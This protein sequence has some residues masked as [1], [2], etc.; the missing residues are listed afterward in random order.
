MVTTRYSGNYVAG[1]YSAKAPLIK[2]A[3]FKP[4]PVSARDPR[5]SKSYQHLI[6]ALRF[7]VAKRLRPSRKRNPM[8]KGEIS[9]SSEQSSILKSLYGLGNQYQPCGQHL[10]ELGV[11][12]SWKPNI[13]NTCY[14]NRATFFVKIKPSS[15]LMFRDANSQLQTV[16]SDEKLLFRF[17]TF[18]S[19]N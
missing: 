11:I 5:R 3:K 4:T 12:A 17:R 15:K 10:D 8:N 16:R 14:I 18:I 1:Q 19:I 6:K 9:L 7:A 13:N 2:T